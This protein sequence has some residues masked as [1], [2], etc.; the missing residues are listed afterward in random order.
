MDMTD[1]VQSAKTAADHEALAKHYEEGAKEMRAKAEEHKKM[2]AQYR[3]KK[4]LYRKQAQDL[5]NHCQGLI[6]VYEQAAADNLSMAK[7]HREIAAE[8]R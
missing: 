2:L 7:S 8:A 6:R 4:D 3:A 5:I 1:A